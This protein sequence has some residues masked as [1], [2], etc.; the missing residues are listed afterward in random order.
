MAVGDVSIYKPASKNSK[1]R[2]KKKTAWDPTPQKAELVV[3]KL[4]GKGAHGTEGLIVITSQEGAV[5]S[6]L[7]MLPK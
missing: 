3:E 1:V 2:T 6:N 5:P 7:W 4:S